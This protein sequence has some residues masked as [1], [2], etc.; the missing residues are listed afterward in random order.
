[1]INTKDWARKITNNLGGAD[2]NAFEAYLIGNETFAEAATALIESLM[3]GDETKEKLATI[4]K[5]VEKG[6]D[7]EAVVREECGS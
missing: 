4:L 3:A 2:R 5:R 6:E 7:A 1:M